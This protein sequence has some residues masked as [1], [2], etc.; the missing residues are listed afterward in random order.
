[1]TTVVAV[2]HPQASVKSGRR[3]L[4][5]SFDEGAEQTRTAQIRGGKGAHLAEMVGLGLPVPHGFTVTT[6]VARAYQEHKSMP[7]R[8]AGQF[9]RAISALERRTGRQLGNPER[10]LLVSVRSGARASMPGMM[11]TV[12]NVGITPDILPALAARNGD[13]FAYGVYYRFLQQF[14]RHVLEAPEALFSN[15][16]Q[17]TM[18]GRCEALLERWDTWDT[19]PLL[20]TPREQLELTFE[21][22]QRSW[23]SD[24]A[25]LYRKANNLP[26]W[27]GTAVNVQSMVFGNL[28]ERSGTGVVFSHD[29]NGVPGLFG[30]YLPSAQGEDLVAGTTTPQGVV[31]LR[32]QMPSVYAELERYVSELSVRYRDIVDVEFTVEDG[33]LYLLQVRSAKRTPLADVTSKVHMVWSGQLSKETAVKSVSTE[34]LESLQSSELA[35]TTAT[36][37]GKGLA[38][39]PG[40]ASGVVVRS[41]A[42]AVRLSA[43]GT[44]VVLVMEETSPDDLAGMMS[45]AAIVTLRGGATCHASVVARDLG[46]PAV[47]G[48]SLPPCWMVD[49]VEL[50]VDGTRGHVYPGVLDVERS[51]ATKEV[52]LFQKWQ[53]ALSARPVSFEKLGERYSANQLLNDFYLTD[54]MAL[55]ARGSSLESDARKLRDQIHEEIAGIFA[56]YLL[57]AVA[58]EARHAPLANV[59][60][61]VRRWPSL[62]GMN[63]AGRDVLRHEQQANA[64]EYLRDCDQDS[65]KDFFA[66]C[67]ELFNQPVWSSAFGGPKWAAIAC[68]G[69]HYLTGELS[70][71]AFVDHVFDLR[72]NGGRLFDKHPVLNDATTEGALPMQLDAKRD[73]TSIQSLHHV[74]GNSY[75]SWGRTVGFSEDVAAMWRRGQDLRVWKEE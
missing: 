72:H 14:G 30:E 19:T 66:M 1:M 25:T 41:S 27:W 70:V 68:A 54:A 2:T 40:A 16:Q 6:T 64:V 39:S 61:A 44:P 9:D 65:A 42:E 48:A 49:E 33:T 8:F 4:V 3:Q 74:L 55:E 73:A 45:A 53:K 56:V 28:N 36:P 35:S 24:R 38:A 50:T 43:T 21:A 69:K 60:S 46:L 15:L 31:S 5:F 57:V 34:T 29:V 22:V 26:A 51:T 12:L 32:D 11:D 75:S 62:E 20:Y 63:W 67:E 23:W 52:N 7:A 18:V 17:S 47:V 10:P 13:E 59:V 58:G 37:I 71:T